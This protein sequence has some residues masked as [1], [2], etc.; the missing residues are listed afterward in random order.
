MAVVK[1]YDL[2]YHNHVIIGGVRIGGYGDDAALEYEYGGDQF[3][4]IVGADGEVT[5]SALNDNRMYVTITL[6]E[7]S[8][9][10]KDLEM[11]RKIQRSA[12]R[13]GAIPPMPYNHVD[14]IRGDTITSA[15]AVFMDLP[16][17]TKARTAGTREFR[18]LLPYSAE[19]AVQAALNFL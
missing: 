17:P 11:L 8:A 18:I 9:S 3:E 2:K 7:T 12:A 13:V 10:V 1:N 5:V 15:Y 4:D 6:M 14:H 16:A 19:D